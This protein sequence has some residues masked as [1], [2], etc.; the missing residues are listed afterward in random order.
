[1]PQTIVT[2]SAL[3][4]NL[5][6]LAK[7]NAD[8]AQKL[9]EVQPRPDVTFV[10][11]RQGV[12]AVSLADMP[13]CSRH[14]PLDEAKRL[15]EG[16]DLVEHAVVVVLGF[17]AG[18]HVQHLAQR[19]GKAGVIVVFEP[20]VALM[21]AVFERID[22]SSW[23]ADAILVWIT[24]P[25]DRGA[26]GKKLEGA[27]SII[28][29]GVAFLEH[30][31]SRQRLA[32]ESKQ[33]T[34]MFSEYV[35]AA[36]TTLMTTLIRSV[37]TV[38]NYLLN[39]DH[40]AA[41]AGIGEL[42]DTAKG[43]PA[44]VV[45]AGPS[46]AKN[47]H[48][49]AQGDVRQR[50]VIVAVQTTLRPLLQAG[51]R[52]HFVTALDYHEISRRFYEGITA[53]DVA[54]VTLIA[55]AKA[56]PVILDAFPGPVR[57]CESK[58]LDEL[59]GDLKRPMGTLPQGATVAHLAVY[60]ARFLGCDPIILIGQDL[61]FSDGLYY[62]P[63]T[64]IHEVWAPEL[65]PFNTIEMME[66]QRIARHRLILHKCRDVHGKSIY[67]DTQMQTYLHQF[68]RDFARYEQ[69]GIEIID[70]TEGGIAKQHTKTM[71]L[72]EALDRYA[73]RSIGALP[74]PDRPLDPKLLPKVRNRV[75]S[76]RRDIAALQDT[77]RKTAT[78]IRKMLDDQADP[79]KMTR[80]FKKIQQYR[81][82]VQQ[83][84]AAFRILDHLNQLG[85][86]KRFKADRRLNLQRDGDPMQ[87]QRA[88]LQ[89]DLENVTWIADSAQEI[90]DQLAEAERLLAGDPVSVRSKPTINLLD[91]D[92]PPAAERAAR[93]A[94]LVPVDPHHNALGVARSLTEQFADRPVLQATLERL[95]RSQALESIILI[96]PRGFDAQAIIDTSR[97]ALPVRIEHCDGSPY[98]PEHPVIAA[99]RLW[100]DTCWRG[101]IAGMSI[102]DEVLCPKVMSR[103]M[104]Q[105]SLTA[106]LL[107]GADWPLVDVSAEGGCDAIIA[108]H[109]E[110]PQRHNL[111]FNQ[112][113][114]GLCGCVVTATLMDEL[115]QRNRLSTIGG[116]LVYQPHAPQHDPIARNINVL[117]DHRV[118][119][120]RIR[121]TF[122]APRY[123]RRLRE[124]IE[125]Q[126]RRGDPT[127]AE[128]VAALE[129]HRLEQPDQL[130][131]HIILELCT[132]RRSCGV[133]NRN[134]IASAKRPPLSLALAEHLF[135]QL[136]EAGDAVV[137]LGG[138]GDP[139]LHQHFDEIV[140]LAKQAGV[141]GVHVRTEL[142]VDQT[143]LDRLLSCGADVVSVDIHA[144]CAETYR[145]MMGLDRFDEVL[146]NI[147]YL[148]SN[149]RRLTD[150]SPSAALDLPWIVGRLQRRMET[151]EDIEG[152]FDRWQRTLGTAVLEGPGPH[153]SAPP[154][155]GGPADMLIPTYAPR[156][157]MLDEGRRR[158]TVYSDGSVPVSELDLA[159]EGSIGNV[160]D[161]PLAELWHDLLEQRR[162]LEDEQG[163]DA[164]ALW[165][166]CP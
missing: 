166:C 154:G 68:E 104:Q 145:L 78:L 38:R 89:R 59:L 107:V 114:P 63:G 85:V 112:A 75:A 80:H 8:L 74:L 36:K 102:Y 144:D 27:E 48:L 101:G 122:D 147:Q 45:S 134:R 6:S 41:G 127:P 146:A 5:R 165:T 120:S 10:Q 43:H 31:P 141:R 58:F 60:V 84:F 117:I 17:A 49:L 157:V 55:D 30:P 151:Y 150:H 47:M 125:A 90:I 109:L 21:R 71:P 105:Q 29:Q 95:G 142:L 14:R 40:Y 164:E 153:E 34:T 96:V 9:G 25:T 76:V 12:A 28:A 51:V 143:I 44:V 37:D 155:A 54:D 67:T 139:L 111:V 26:L 119:R 87:H 52:P 11:S 149:R 100:S 62:T 131:Q 86:F 77:A 20:D 92:G 15:T 42:Q 121:A 98:G 110:L 72:A 16:I 158:M 56:H 99:A 130:P 138:L 2:P 32:Q 94:A 7:R 124:A 79:A 106:A 82:Q 57:C 161:A 133:F 163:Q 24:D 61:A 126:C 50:C 83:R 73:T 162:R 129:R 88:Q 123:R 137:T 116:L 113:P 118:S 22:H 91:I 23:L 1:M 148:L 160:L 65:N 132:Q 4:S 135:G 18:Y 97:I 115:A 93:I 156:R 35:S 64:A 19:Y 53:D 66:W 70:A 33:F 140:R 128:I 108:R 39:L 136:A 159:G 13:L 3:G 152:F 81:N 103:I 69:E 46:L